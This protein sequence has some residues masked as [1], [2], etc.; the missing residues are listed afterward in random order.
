MLRLVG[1]SCFVLLMISSVFID[2]CVIL[3]SYVVRL[4]SVCVVLVGI[5]CLKLGCV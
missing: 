1:G 5:S 2:S 4:L 3:V